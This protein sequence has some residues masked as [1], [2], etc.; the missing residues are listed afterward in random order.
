[1]GD[2]RTQNSQAQKWTRGPMRSLGTIDL[3]HKPEKGCFYGSTGCL[4]IDLAISP[5]KDVVPHVLA[6]ARQIFDNGN[7]EVLEH[8]GGT[9]PWKP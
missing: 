5:P 6:N 8:I 7:A 4:N 3:Q 1:M 9:N 2:F